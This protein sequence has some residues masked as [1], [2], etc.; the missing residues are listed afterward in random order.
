MGADKSQH[1]TH[2]DK[3]AGW[4]NFPE[5]TI[6]AVWLRRLERA[7]QIDSILRLPRLAKLRGS[8]AIL[9]SDASNRER[10]RSLLMRL[11]G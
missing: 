11:D 5:A 3:G 10:Y 1:I 7:Y 8:I 4:S 9:R 6:D 2:Y